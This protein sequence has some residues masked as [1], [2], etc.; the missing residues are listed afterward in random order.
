[1]ISKLGLFILCAVF[2]AL[3]NLFADDDE[4]R[5]SFD[6]LPKAVQSTVLEATKLDQIL[7]IESER[8]KGKRIYDVEFR[9]GKEVVELE[10]ASDGTILDR[11]IEKGDGGHLSLSDLP[12]A[13]KDTILKHTA[14]EAILELER[15]NKKGVVSYEAEYHDGNQIVELEIS[16]DG[17]LLEKEIE[18]D[19]DEEDDDDDDDDDDED[20]EDDD[21]D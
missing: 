4:E 6:Q 17:K 21:N 10:I 20:E 11:E 15:E 13:V 2:L 8:E 3:P 19:H 9:A 14:L 16:P 12:A 5:L 18:D 7:E 1:M